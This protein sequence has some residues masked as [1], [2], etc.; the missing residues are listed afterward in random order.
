MIYIYICTCNKCRKIKTKIIENYIF[1]IYPDSRGAGQGPRETVI[2]R[3]SEPVQ[4][5]SSRSYGTFY[6]QMPENQDKNY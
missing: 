5:S 2:P 4:V 6:G 1:Y 3:V